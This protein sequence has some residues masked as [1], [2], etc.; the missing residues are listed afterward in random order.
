M[1]NSRSSFIFGT[2]CSLVLFFLKIILVLN[3]NHIGLQMS[4]FV[5]TEYA[6]SGL[7][8]ALNI[9]YILLSI[10]G[11]SNHSCEPCFNTVNVMFLGRRA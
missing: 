10:L 11:F 7:C 8:R 4:E 3:I 1:T 2:D 5:H 6:Q 9:H